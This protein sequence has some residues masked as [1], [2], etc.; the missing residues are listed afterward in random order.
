MLLV[1]CQQAFIYCAPL[2]Y[3]MERHKWGAALEAAKTSVGNKHLF[4]LMAASAVL[5]TVRVIQFRRR[6][7]LPRVR[8]LR[9]TCSAPDWDSSNR[10]SCRL[11]AAIR[12]QHVVA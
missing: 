12:G 5:Y 10:L 4:T 3:V 1:I 6:S 7:L 2:A 8:E 9:S 11:Q